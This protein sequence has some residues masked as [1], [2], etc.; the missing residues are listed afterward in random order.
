M[1]GRGDLMAAGMP[2]GQAVQIGTSLATALTAS[3]T[4]KAAALVLAAAINVFGTVSSGK[5]C[6]LPAASGSPPIAVLNG[7]ANSLAI[8]TGN[9]VDVID[10]L[11]TGASYTLTNAKKVLFYPHSGQWIAIKSA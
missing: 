1:S 3:G 5:A 2:A 10:S 11:S 4:T 6:A 9:S 7:G 8:F